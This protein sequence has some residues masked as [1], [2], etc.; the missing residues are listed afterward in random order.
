MRLQTKTYFVI[1]YSDLLERG[2]Q[3][4]SRLASTQFTDKMALRR[5]AWVY[6]LAFNRLSS[7]PPTSVATTTVRACV[8]TSRHCGAIS[9]KPMRLLFFWV[10]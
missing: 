5:R 6:A 7:M 2:S 3:S 8:S 10:S 1:R 4:V 9:G